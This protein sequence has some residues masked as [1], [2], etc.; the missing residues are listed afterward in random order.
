M[1]DILHGQLKFSEYL[2]SLRKTKVESVFCRRDPL[3]S[4]V[5]ALLL[6]YLIVKKLA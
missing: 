4:I 2:A 3:P 5:E 6:P 1:S